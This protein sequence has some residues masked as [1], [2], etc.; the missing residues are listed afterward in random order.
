MESHQHFLLAY[1]DSFDDC[2][3]VDMKIVERYRE[4]PGSQQ[5]ACNSKI[6]Q[7]QWQTLFPSFPESNKLNERASLKNFPSSKA[8][9][10]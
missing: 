2:V 7:T 9:Q 6:T 8:W 3:L 10:T 5:R 4:E 1:L